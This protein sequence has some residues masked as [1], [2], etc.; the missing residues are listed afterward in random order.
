[1]SK[2]TILEKH[3]EQVKQNIEE[4]GIDPQIGLGKEMMRQ[5]RLNIENHNQI[6]ELRNELNELKKRP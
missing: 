6:I 5:F 2:I 4:S 1:M 3:M